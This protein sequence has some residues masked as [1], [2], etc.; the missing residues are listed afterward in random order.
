[1][2]NFG[3]LPGEGDTDGYCFL[4]LEL[5]RG[6]PTE[7]TFPGSPERSPGWGPCSHRETPT[8][9]AVV[10]HT[11]PWARHPGAYSR[12]STL[13]LR[14]ILSR[15]LACVVRTHTITFQLCIELRRPSDVLLIVFLCFF[16]KQSICRPPSCEANITRP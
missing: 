10:E 11:N 9:S 2:N 14:Q 3:F 7:L 16:S 4:E 13:H 6:H 5:K 1:M 8:G 15:R 12:A